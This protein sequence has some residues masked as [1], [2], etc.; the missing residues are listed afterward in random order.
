[1]SA[2]VF[3]LSAWRQEHRLTGLLRRRD[4]N[5]L[6]DLFYGQARQMP[7]P[8][9]QLNQ[10]W[11]ALIQ[12]ICQ[13]SCDIS[14]AN[15]MNQRMTVRAFLRGHRPPQAALDQAWETALLQG[16]PDILL[17]LHMVLDAPSADT[18]VRCGHLLAGRKSLAVP[19]ASVP[20]PLLW[21]SLR[22]LRLAGWNLNAA[23][24]GLMPLDRAL[25]HEDWLLMSM[26]CEQ[27]A[28]ASNWVNTQRVRQG[29]RR[30]Q[31]HSACKAW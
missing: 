1:M 31:G 24:A 16:R 28:Q 15:A 12:G 23:V 21:Q 2:A 20:G 27:G 6:A 9:A 8:L 25:H 14:C 13:D 19:L 22:V 7:P 29:L 18:L 5:G 3:S 4:W 11:Q 17:S 10:E 30:H 26:M